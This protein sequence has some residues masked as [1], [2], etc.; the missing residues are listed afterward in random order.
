MVEAD[1]ILYL[2]EQ[3][4][5][6]AHLSLRQSFLTEGALRALLRCTALTSLDLAGVVTMPDTL[7]PHTLPP[8]NLVD[9]ELLALAAAM[10]GLSVLDLSRQGRASPAALALAARLPGGFHGQPLRM[11]LH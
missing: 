4:P 10:A 6:L 5:R 3:M 9:E 11:V 7:R 1:A 8:G 2:A